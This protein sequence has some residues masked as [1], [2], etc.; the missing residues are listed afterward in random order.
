MHEM[1][2]AMVKQFRQSRANRT[3]PA[4]RDP[5]AQVPLSEL[6]TAVEKIGDTRQHSRSTSSTVIMASIVEKETAVAEERP[7]VASVYYNRLDKRHRARRRPQHHLRRTSGG[8]LS[9]RAAP[10][11]H[12]LHF[13]LQHLPQRRT[14]SRPHRQSRT[15]RARSRHASRT[16]R[17]LTTSSPTPRATTASPA[18]SKNT[19]RM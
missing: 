9:G 6:H 3:D 18:R 5:G 12:E 2:A 7:M 19:T 13:P 1:A 11:R 16:N 4:D 10:R 14:P 15:Q 17:L 8:N